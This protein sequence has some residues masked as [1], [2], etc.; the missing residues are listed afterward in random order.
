M[1]SPQSL[2]PAERQLY[3][4]LRQIL[5]RPGLLRGGLTGMRRTCGNGSCHCSK[6]G[7][8]KHRSV[9]LA[10]SLKGKS[11]LIYIPAHW[12]QRIREWVDRYRQVRDVLEQLS[13]ACLKR[14]QSREE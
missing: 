13:L 14:L 11:R 9:Y 5:I 4:K 12:E 10:T 7:R 1:L 8:H 2:P 3:S 6:G